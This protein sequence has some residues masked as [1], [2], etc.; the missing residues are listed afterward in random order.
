VGAELVIA[1]LTPSMAGEAESK[2]REL[3][4][5]DT[6]EAEVKLIFPVVCI[7]AG[8]TRSH[9]RRARE[10]ALSG[11]PKERYFPL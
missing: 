9:R 11:R 7:T 5:S 6:A 2:Q 10:S 8:N 4:G 1:S 3:A